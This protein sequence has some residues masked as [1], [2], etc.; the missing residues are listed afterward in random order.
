MELTRA[1]VEKNVDECCGQ[2]DIENYRQVRAARQAILAHDQAQR[3]KLAEVARERDEA[4]RALRHHGYRKSCDIPACNC[5]DQ[6]HHGG[7]AV[8]RLLEIG[9]AL[10]YVNGKTILM[11]VKEMCQQLAEAQATIAEAQVSI[12]WWMNAKD[13]VERSAQATIQR[14]TAELGEAKRAQSNACEECPQLMDIRAN[15]YGHQIENG[16]LTQRV[17]ALEARIKELEHA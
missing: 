10:P 5:G 6:W 17:A 12:N 9:E 13:E 1:Q 16:D 2:I 15:L 8:E 7:Y 11:T 3:E 14:L 4:E